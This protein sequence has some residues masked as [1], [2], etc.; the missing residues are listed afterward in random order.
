MFSGSLNFTVTGGTLTNIT[1]HYHESV[2]SGGSTLGT[3]MIPP[4]DIYLCHEIRVD[5][6]TGILERG[7]I[8]R[9]YLLIQIIAVV[10]EPIRLS[11]QTSRLDRDSVKGLP[12]L[13]VILFLSCFVDANVSLLWD[14]RF[15]QLD[16]PDIPDIYSSTYT[17]EGC[18]VSANQVIQTNVKALAVSVRQLCRDVR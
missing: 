16:I 8:R 3:Q 14:T 6:D 15:S 18:H 5:R 4:E 13:R 11:R 1:N 10:S 17:N 7:A 9:V 2:P 12:L